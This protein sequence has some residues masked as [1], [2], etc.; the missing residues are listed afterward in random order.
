[1][2]VLIKEPREA[3]VYDGKGNVILPVTAWIDIIRMR[4]EFEHILSQ[5]DAGSILSA[6]K[7][8]KEMREERS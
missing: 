3:E 8:V 6:V 4:V 2:R 1:M 7:I 5:P